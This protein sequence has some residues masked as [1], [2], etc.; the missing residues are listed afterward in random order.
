MVVRV[1]LVDDYHP[2]FLFIRSM[3]QE[4]W[5]LQILAEVSD[6][7]EAVQ[8]AVELQPDLILLDIGLPTLNGIEAAR[9]IRDHSPD[10][11]IIFVSEQRSLDVIT[12]AL[13]TGSGCV[14]KSCAPRDLLPAIKAVLAGGRFVSPALDVQNLTDSRAERVQEVHSYPDQAAFVDG[15]ARF[16]GKALK[17]GSAIVVLASESRRVGIL[18]RLKS[19]GV[20]VA[21]AIEQK[22][23][24]PLDIPDGFQTFQLTEQLATDAVKAARERNVPV[25]LG[26][27]YTPLQPQGKA[28]EPRQRECQWSEFAKRWD[29]GHWCGRIENS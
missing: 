27:E 3:L 11:K 12:E 23:Y 25:A 5:E 2:W 10:A 16:V 26:C 28:D 14:L 4:A 17:N 7:R 1:L 22:R 9:Q 19:Q 8:K 24:F 18:Q 29:I 21:A 13:S 6:G 20:D 15:F